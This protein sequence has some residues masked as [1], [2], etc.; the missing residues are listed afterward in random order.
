MMWQMNDKLEQVSP[1]AN[2]ETWPDFPQLSGNKYQGHRMGE[3]AIG[4][5][6]QHK[7]YDKGK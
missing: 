7:M 6:L 4:S 2:E 5:A 3:T 1:E